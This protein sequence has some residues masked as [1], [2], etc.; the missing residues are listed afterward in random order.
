MVVTVLCGIENGERTC[1]TVVITI[2]IRRCIITI[3]YTMSR[4]DITMCQHGKCPAAFLC[5]FFISFEDF[6][7]VCVNYIKI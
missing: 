4:V 3:T 5:K 7:I 6:V 2:Q 1:S